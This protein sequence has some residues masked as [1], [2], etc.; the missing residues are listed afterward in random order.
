MGTAAMEATAAPTELLLNGKA[1]PMKPWLNVTLKTAGTQ[2]LRAWP[3]FTPLSHMARA[4]QDLR[5]GASGGVR[6][7][8]LQDRV[9]VEEGALRAP[10]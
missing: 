6:P 5:Q 2:G 3:L 7:P 1:A 9:T 10:S 4:P 8:G